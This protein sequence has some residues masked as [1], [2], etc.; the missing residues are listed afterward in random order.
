MSE[1]GERGERGNFRVRTPG[2]GPPAPRE[3]CHES[4]GSREEARKKRSDDYLAA[5]FRG[6]CQPLVFCFT[7]WRVA[8][9]VYRCFG[10]MGRGDR[11]CPTQPV[12]VRPSWE[13]SSAR[14]ACRGVG[15]V[16]SPDDE[17]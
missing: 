7:L 5:R 13:R 12:P 3:A 9:I 10:W 11:R 2:G 8:V 1:G 15:T 16:H 4:A 6:P 17:K 14:S